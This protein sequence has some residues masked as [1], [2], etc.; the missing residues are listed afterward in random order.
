MNADA[1]SWPVRHKVLVVDPLAPRALEQ[2]RARYDVT[3]RMQPSEAE[4]VDLMPGMEAIV[5]RSGVELSAHVIN[6]A[7]QLKVIARAGNGTDNIDLTAARRAGIQVFNI[8]G[9]SSGSV[10][11]L[12][13]GLTYA[14]TRHIA[15]ADRQV[16]SNIWRKSELAGIELAGRTMGVV[17]LGSIGARLA[18]LACGVGMKAV[19]SVDRP[20]PERKAE[21]ARTG[22]TLMSIGEVLRNADVVALTCPLNDRTHHLITAA[23]LATMKPGA[24]LVNVSR[25][26]VVNENDLYDALTRGHIAGAA[27]DVLATEREP[28]RLSELDNVVLTPHIGAMSVD[29]QT[30]IG[31]M[32]LDGLALGLTCQ[33]APTRIV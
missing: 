29:S 14:V 20:T 3:V 30:R 4:L 31:A 25:G 12:A 18:A 33:D 5:L 10:A 7:R 8:P 23:E 13:L 27:I 11:E 19:G 1:P 26:G 9:V 21:F 16:R 6:G 2:L 17:G 32:L 15:L 24:Y 22:I 28:S